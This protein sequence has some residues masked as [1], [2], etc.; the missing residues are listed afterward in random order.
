MRAIWGDW[1]S[2]FIKVVHN[3]LGGINIE[4][5]HTCRFIIYTVYWSNKI[6]NSLLYFRLLI[7]MSSLCVFLSL[8]ISPYNKQNIKWLRED[9]DLCSRVKNNISLVR[10]A[11]S[12]DI[13]FA[14]QTQN[15]YYPRN[16]LISS[17]YIVQSA[18]MHVSA[19][20]ASSVK[21]GTHLDTRDDI[22]IYTH[23]VALTKRMW[24]NTGHQRIQTCAE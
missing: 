10:C 5:M 17:I 7:Y 14:T 4:S 11:H 24:Y 18:D 16:R 23:A 19:Y 6:W 22:R 21:L 13:I 20:Y 1:L 2:L 9:M 12:W 3:Y 15:P 8:W